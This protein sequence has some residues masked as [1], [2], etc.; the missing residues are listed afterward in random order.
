MGGGEESMLH[1]VMRALDAINGGRG[2]EA[3]AGN[4]LG[5]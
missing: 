3:R 1:R 2:E 5:Q 4:K